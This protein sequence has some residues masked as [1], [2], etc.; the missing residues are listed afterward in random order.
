[1]LC[2]NHAYPKDVGVKPRFAKGNKLSGVDQGQAMTYALTKLN[3]GKCKEAG[4]MR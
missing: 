3:E 4:N 2:V 1:M